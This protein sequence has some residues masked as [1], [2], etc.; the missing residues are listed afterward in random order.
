[1]RHAMPLHP[2]LYVML[3][4]V[5]SLPMLPAQLRRCVEACC[6]QAAIRACPWTRQLLGASL[7]GKSQRASAR[8]AASQGT[9]PPDWLAVGRRRRAT[10]ALETAPK[11]AVTE[12]P[13]APAEVRMRRSTRHGRCR[14]QPLPWT[15]GRTLPTATN[16]IGLFAHSLPCDKRHN[17]RA[18]PMCACACQSPRSLASPTLAGEP[19]LAIGR[20]GLVSATLR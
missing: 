3:R 1:M 7:S 10:R 16:R 4:C 14:R 5:G 18:T 6:S 9:P 17:I 15:D 12:L 13:M 8:A 11:G 2:P 19:T 20:P